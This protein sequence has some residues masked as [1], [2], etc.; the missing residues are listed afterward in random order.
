MTKRK[1]T[2]FGLTVLTVMAVAV[3][4]WATGSAGASP[5]LKPAAQSGAPLLLNYQG[6]LTDPGTGDLVPDGVYN[7]T[8][9]IHDAAA[10]GTLIW[11]E[12]QA[13]TVNG[14]L[15]NVLLGS[16]TALSVADF[17]GTVRWL[18]LVVEGETLT[19]RVRIVS[20]PY[21]I[22]AEEAKNA[23][24]LDGQDSSYYQRRVAS[25]CTS[26]NA[27][28]VINQ[29][30]TVTCES[31][32][33]GA[34]DI[35][36]V[37]TGTGLTG[38]GDSGDV[39]LALGAT[40]RL[41]Q[42]CTNG[43]VAKWNTT[44][45]ACDDD[46]DS[47]G[48]ITAVT[49]GTG[50]SDGGASGSVTLNA[51][52]TYLQRRVS[53]TCTAGSSIRV[54]N[55]DGTV[56]CETDDTGAGGGN[57]LDQAY[58]QGGPG[59]GRTITADTGAV[60][61]AGTGGLEVDNTIKS[62]TSIIIDGTDGTDDKITGSANLDF[63]VGGSLRA[64]RLENNATS[65][66]VIG[67]YSGNSVT[68]GVKGATIG[69]GGY[70]ANV[71]SVT[72]NYGTVSGGESNTASGQYAT[73]GGGDSN[74][75][76]YYY[77][78]VGGGELNTASNEYATVG[79][80]YQNTASGAWATVG[81]GNS[82]TASG[83]SDGYGT[84]PGGY[85]NEATGDYSF[86]AGKRAKANHDGAFVWADSTDA[87]FASTANDQF[88][89]R[90]T[91]GV[92]LTIEGGGLRLLPNTTSPNVI[93][94]YSGNSVT[95]GKY[96]ATIGG[97]GASGNANS[98][99]A[100]YATVGGGEKNTASGESSTVGGGRS[101]TASAQYSTV[102]GGNG[103]TAGSYASTVGGGQNNSAGGSRATVGGGQDNTATDFY[104]TVG[105]GSD[106][107]A[108]GRISTVGGGQSNTA[109][110]F[111]ATV[112]GGGL[113]V[114]S[115]ISGTI[116]GGWSN[117]VGGL[118]AT[119]GGGAGNTAVYTYTTV[120]GGYENTASGE[121]ATVGGGQDN[122]A[123]AGWS[124]VGGGD[125]NTASG[126]SATVGGGYN[127]IASGEDAT[128]GGGNTN[129][130]TG[131]SATVG[132]GESNEASGSSATVGGGYQNTASEDWAT[133]GGGQS[134]TASG[135]SATVGGG[136]Q[137][138]ASGSGTGNGF[139]TVGGG[140]S[141]LASA[142][143]ATIGGG[144]TNVVSG[145]NATVGGG[146]LNTASGN[147]STVGG[148]KSNKASNQYATVG[149]GWN[150]T[151]SGGTWGSATVGGGKNNTASDASSTVS[152]GEGNTADGEVATVGGGASNTASG[153]RATV[154]GG[155][156][157][158]ASG[159]W[160]TISGGMYNVADGNYSFAAGYKA[161]A[162]HDG[163]FVW[164]DSTNT[165]FTSTAD[166][167]FM[168]QASGGITMY[169]NSGRTL[170][171]RAP[172][173]GTAWSS[174]SDRELKENF[175]PVD[176]QELLARLAESPITTWNYKSQAPSIRHI[177][178]MAQ[179]FNTLIEGLGGEG[180]KYINTLDADGVAL[181][182]I[183]GLY[184][185][186]QTLAAENAALREHVAALDDRMAALEA[187]SRAPLGS[188]GP[189]GL[190]FGGLLLGLVVVRRNDLGKRWL[191]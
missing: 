159:G 89:V 130:V 32:A 100:N 138:T 118:A 75:A 99:T 124:T 117:A 110:G 139:A 183:Q 98:A 145:T 41:P 108:S 80:G 189:L 174:A 101:N 42:A 168:V 39:T 76:S 170:G 177:G 74:T 85:E 123:S 24:L 21:A 71:N 114:T 22:Q 157:N 92:S 33:G 128:V 8:F 81:G 160:S 154:G 63:E 2:T 59:V 147:N 125:I 165:D 166:D 10:N 43:Q 56:T 87:D 30:G 129:V 175:A 120:S 44:A 176:T 45:W 62:G 151:A 126:N 179:D 55:A 180:E 7:I 134:N 156:L 191:L 152:G 78:T 115:G 158:T 15:F 190:L 37:Y 11:F 5:P 104:S 34:G 112:G 163:A 93:G 94:G 109:S 20:V 141:N 68:S 77:A 95:A 19:P 167:Q 90:A 103:N 146:Y 17:D 162:N 83:T 132:G 136:Y 40:Y 38:G 172:A 164:A 23:D 153:M 171:V 49:A 58:D 149:G 50:L 14:G 111:S 181:A 135:F 51:D 69:G 133:V 131:T 72:A 173:D 6:R 48:D 107:T 79:G 178:P 16:V 27:I 26:G 150:N 148:G 4:L 116:S 113:N 84:V 169:T 13:V 127:N 143:Y 65:P 188:W 185:Q 66:N 54:I 102:D 46:A 96:G 31:I 155:Q 18:E 121:A 186:N 122:I 60:K 52:T 29:D 47:G 25:P 184:E 36:T 105:G 187:Q 106:N 182:A 86:A 91:G 119:V 82:N 73:V 12:A 144:Q 3:L 35:T 140:E 61:I 97:G 67:G 142:D 28:R 64:L 161:K 88:M 9:N 1:I 137:N 57:T 53:S 70:S